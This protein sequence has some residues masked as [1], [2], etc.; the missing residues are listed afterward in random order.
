MAAFHRQQF[1]GTRN[2]QQSQLVARSSLA[3]PSRSLC[4]PLPQLRVVRHL[5]SL[6][7]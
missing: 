2:A 5:E 3:E 4:A 7:S 1:V 6:G